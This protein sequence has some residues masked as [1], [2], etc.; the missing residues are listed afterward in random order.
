MM[1]Y[2]TATLPIP[3]GGISDIAIE[4]IKRHVD[5]RSS[6]IV[7]VVITMDEFLATASFVPRGTLEDREV[8]T[9][10]IH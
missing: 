9:G 7:G 6:I 4:S 8:G 2:H 10:R 1:C 5:S 3:L